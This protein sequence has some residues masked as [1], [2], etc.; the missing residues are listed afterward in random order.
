MPHFPSFGPFAVRRPLYAPDNAIAH[1]KWSDFDDERVVLDAIVIDNNISGSVPALHVRASDGSNWTI[2]LGR[3]ARND[4]AGLTHAQAL[5]GD[6]VAVVG[7][8]AHRFG[9]NRIKA[10]HV[11]IG[12]RGFD[13]YPEAEAV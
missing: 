10:L 11:T 4:A 7:R 2:E 13:L 1:D 5:P 3:H 8:P 6:H 12:D 9:E